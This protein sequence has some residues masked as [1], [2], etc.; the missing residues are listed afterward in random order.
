MSAIFGQHLNCLFSLFGCKKKI[1]EEEEEEEEEA[2]EDFSTAA[3]EVK[4][5]RIIIERT[6]NNLEHFKD[7]RSNGQIYLRAYI[8][9]KKYEIILLLKQ[10]TKNEIKKKIRRWLPVGCWQVA[11]PFGPLDGG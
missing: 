3:A 5:S 6:R 1:E 7:G 11:L 4:C 9:V 10:H 2:E 8:Y